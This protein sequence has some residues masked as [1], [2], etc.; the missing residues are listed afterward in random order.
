[1]TIEQM[2]RDGIA[3]LRIKLLDLTNRNRLVNFKFSETSR[4]FVRVVDEVPGILFER[5][6]DDSARSPKLYF[7]SL[8]APPPEP[9]GPAEEADQLQLSPSVADAANEAKAASEKAARPR[10]KK[11]KL[12]L[13]INLQEWAHKHGIEPSF[14]LPEANDNSPQKHLDNSIQTLLLPEQLDSKL[15]RIRE[16]ARLAYQELGLGTLF[17]AFGFLEWYESASSKEPVHSPLLLLPVQIDRELKYGQYR[18]FIEA[19]DG[20]D[21]LTNVSLRERLRKDFNIVL[22]EV[23]EEDTPDSYAKRIAKVIDSQKRW[24]IR[25]F[26][27]IGHFA[28]ARLAMYEDLALSR[29]TENPLEENPLISTLL[30]GAQDG[31]S[32]ALAPDFDVDDELIEAHVPVTITDADSSQFSAIVDA[33]QGRS[34]ALKGPPGTG[35]SQ[36]ITNLIAAGLAKGKTILFVAEKQA[37][38]DVVAKRLKEAG[39]EHHLFE[40]HSTKM[41]KKK[42]LESLDARLQEP[43][44]KADVRLF[45]TLTELRKTRA[46]LRAYVSALNTPI[47]AADVTL[48]DAY[49]QE[50]R[51]RLNLTP[52]ELASANDVATLPWAEVSAHDFVAHQDLI[53]RTATAHQNC[54]SAY[55]AIA[56]HPLCGLR[57]LSADAWD[58]DQL[59]EL[60]RRW[61]VAL[62]ELEKVSVRVGSAFSCKLPA[63]AQGITDCVRAIDS[64]SDVPASVDTSLLSRIK[65]QTE[66]EALGNLRG[67]VAQIVRLRTELAVTFVSAE[68]V[69]EPADRL[70]PHVLAIDGA[71]Q[72]LLLDRIPAADLPDTIRQRAAFL[73]GALRHVA[74]LGSF[75][76]TSALTG[77]LTHSVLAELIDAVA[78]IQR[79]PPAVLAARHPGLFGNGVQ[80]ALETL[81]EQ[82]ASIRADMGR[83][84]Q[85]MSLTFQESP[86]KLRDAAA[87]LRD[88]NVLQRLFGGPYRAAQ[89][90]F[91]GL[92]K[93]RWP[94]REEAAQLLLQ[95]SETLQKRRT[96]EAQPVLRALAGRAFAGVDTPF[97]VLLDV[98]KFGVAVRQ[99]WPALDATRAPYQKL[100]LTGDTALLEEVATSLGAEDIESLRTY[101]SSQS[102]QSDE[103]VTARIGELQGLAARTLKSAE[104]LAGLQY[105]QPLLTTELPQLAAHL[106]GYRRLTHA[107]QAS[108]LGEVTFASGLADEWDLERITATHRYAQAVLSCALPGAIAHSL[109][110]AKA[111]AALLAARRFAE[112]LEKC[113]QARAGVIR[114][115]A[116]KAEFDVLRTAQCREWGALTLQSEMQV[117][118]NALAVSDDHFAEWSVYRSLVDQCHKLGLKTL[119]E[120]I[121]AERV[122]T[123]TAVQVLRLGWARGLIRHASKENSDIPTWTGEHVEA[124]RKRLVRLDRDYIGLSRQYLAAVLSAIVV[125]VGVSRGSAKEITERSLIER[126]IG[127]QRRHIPTRDLLTRA[128]LAVRALKP[129]FMMSPA[130]VAQFL[131]PGTET[132]DLA[133]IDEAS[134]MAPEEALGVTARAKQLIVVGDP[135]Q[136]P[137]TS[138]FN[139][140]HDEE[141]GEELSEELDIDTESILDLALSSLR[142]PR[143]LRWHYRS[144]HHSLIAFSNREFYDDRLI[145]FPSPKHKSTEMG[146]QS[147]YVKDAT[148][149][150]SLNQLEGETVVEQVAAMM[151]ARPEASIGVVAINQAQMDLLSGLFDHLFAQNEDLEEYRRRWAGTIEEFFV[152]NLENVQGDERDVIIISTV[153]GPE[154][155]GGK[156]M[157]RFGP[158]NAKMGH[159]RL[160]VL[161]TRAKERVVIVTSLRPEDITPPSAES[162]GMHALK[163]YLQFARSGRLNAGEKTGGSYD[164]PFEAEVAAILRDAGHRVEA[165][166]GV[167]G[168][169]I[170]LAVCHPLNT[171]HF[172]LGIECDGASYHSAKSARDRDRLRQEILERLGWSLHR[173]WSTDW[174]HARDREKSRLLARIAQLT[175]PM[176]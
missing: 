108:P 19:G 84:E 90:V 22:P 152:K 59:K 2:V 134:Q 135:M 8:P 85:T 13:K 142:P 124:L 56:R 12:A 104:S 145:V 159:R 106:Q 27:I 88:A 149:K 110:S 111:Q 164:S 126:E 32:D 63:S 11:A 69:L 25:R 99:R 35:K 14:D 100:L 54:R 24:K 89:K 71:R 86:E 101:A 10:W 161:F 150:S 125:P 119:V 137:P 155:A 123:D 43:K 120:F 93:S 7:R 133:I 9:E 73:E 127:K 61:E 130:S 103:E 18:Y 49:W 169:F 94:G 174:F 75:V 157:Q 48:H 139:R 168:Y 26:M 162:R 156:P 39:L 67:L 163:G 148:Y 30:A 166:V 47:G 58:R 81:S 64:L 165:Q 114:A 175:G 74:I 70:L 154:V 105:R 151:R 34:F 97:S 171:D 44:R 113:L 15:S 167:A 42:L 170:D 45:S 65:G 40:L 82:A 80:P 122:R 147:V 23:D 109:L 98:V 136:L 92:S 115:V 72:E 21:P 5:L 143:D 6:T 118:R 140:T 17:A 158:I 4:K 91:R 20:S 83:L 176:E 128:S 173:I 66:L 153:Y 38:L 95:T 16:D 29:W 129:C 112:L 107:V 160:N 121:E 3:R 50:I 55:S 78:M 138:F 141:E 68:S 76:Q 52:H 51:S 79:T 132:F 172:V 28:F 87:T 146:V 102:G 41:N 96:Y 131:P 144:K 1:M 33:M 37:A 46:S 77:P 53:S 57:K 60:W 62:T 116:E 117:L 36:T 31:S